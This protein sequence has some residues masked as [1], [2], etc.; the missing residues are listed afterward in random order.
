MQDHILQ[1]WGQMRAGIT[2]K[3]NYEL[4]EENT[5]HSDS[6]VGY[7]LAGYIDGKKHA[8]GICPN[9]V[10]LP[11]YDLFKSFVN[12]LVP[13]IHLSYDIKE[14]IISIILVHHYKVKSDLPNHPIIH[15][16]EAT[17]KDHGC[18]GLLEIWYE[19]TYLSY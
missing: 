18:E 6:Q 11:S 16:I 9:P 2:A 5:W 10:S 7:V 13:T 19:S 1:R 12:N 3:S 8:R 17:A 14:I 4:Y 15:K